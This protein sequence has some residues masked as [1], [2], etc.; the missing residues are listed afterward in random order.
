MFFLDD[1]NRVKENIHIDGKVYYESE[2]DP[3]WEKLRLMSEC[4]HFV[5]SNSTSS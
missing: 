2:N 1:I 5:I 3:V 4:K